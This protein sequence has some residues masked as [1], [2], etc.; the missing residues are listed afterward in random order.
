M[1]SDRKLC[2][3]RSDLTYTRSLILLLSY[4]LPFPLLR[5]IP[6]LVIHP[7][8]PVYPSLSSY[9]PLHISRA[10]DSLD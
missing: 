3:L 4:F 10:P 2:G 1:L 7:R 5:P 6:L 9:C 8:R